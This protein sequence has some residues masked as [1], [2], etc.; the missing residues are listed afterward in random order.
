MLQKMLLL[1]A[2]VAT[3]DPASGAVRRNVDGSYIHYHESHSHNPEPPPPVD[4]PPLCG[5]VVRTQC[6]PTLKAF[7]D[8]VIRTR[9]SGLVCGSKFEMCCYENDP[10]PGVVD[11]Y[12]H[13]APC[14]SDDA[15]RRPY[16]TEP[17]D[18]RDF[19][20]IPHCPGNGAV[21]C[22][23]LFTGPQQPEGPTNFVV[24]IIPP[25]IGYFPPEPFPIPTPV[26]LPVPVPEPVPTPVYN[27]PV[28]TIYTAPEPVTT[29]VYTAPEPAPTPIYIAP[30]PVPTPIYTAPEPVPTPIYTPP[31]PTPIYTAPEPAPIPIYTP[32]EP[33]PIYTP[34]EPIPIYT[35]P[36]P[37]GVYD[38]PPPPPPSRLTYPY[39][40]SYGPYYGGGLGLGGFGFRKHLSF[41]K[42]FGFIG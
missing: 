18:V 13:L 24:P 20:A 1:A 27:P 29:P 4:G 23:D 17:T 9:A 16:G 26:Y 28:P 32:P 8:L 15:C 33:T 2:V 19:G 10:W 6:D 38:Y 37:T 25:T 40:S 22:L 36:A 7:T 30:E 39:P 35:P 21:R 41:S 42:G 11:N 34:P 31:E 5:C 3:L 12:A 14:V